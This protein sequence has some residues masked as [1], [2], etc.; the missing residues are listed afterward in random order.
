MLILVIAGHPASEE[1]RAFAGYLTGTAA[2]LES[3]FRTFS[4]SG[5]ATFADPLGTEGCSERSLRA[6]H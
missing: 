6:Y 4:G 5:T 1:F 2:F 3:A